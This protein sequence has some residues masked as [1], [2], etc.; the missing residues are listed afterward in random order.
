MALEKTGE[1]L[2]NLRYTQQ[3]DTVQNANV[4]VWVVSNLDTFEG[5]KLVVSAL[6]NAIADP[7]VRVSIIHN[8]NLM[9]EPS[10]RITHPESGTKFS[11]IIYQALY[12]SKISLDDL[13]NTFTSALQPEDHIKLIDQIK[14]YAAGSPI[15]EMITGGHIKDWNNLYNKLQDS[16]LDKHFNGVVVNGRIVGPIPSNYSFDKEDF[17][18]LISHEW[19]KR[20]HPVITAFHELQ[21]QREEGFNVSFTPEMVMQLSSVIT[22]ADLT[23]DFTIFVQQ[24]GG[25]NRVYRK[26]SSDYSRITSGDIDNATYQFGIILDPVSENAQKWSAI[27][28]TLAHL[29]GVHIEIY[30]NPI[31]QL[32]ALPLKRF[33]RYVMDKELHFNEHGEIEHPTAYFANLPEDPLYTLGTEEI[34]SWHISP[35]VANYDLDNILLKSID[36]SQRANGVSAVFELEYILIDGHCRDMSSQGPPRGL[37]FVLGSTNSPSM[38]DTIVMANLGY[39][40]LKANPGVWQLSL[41]EGRSQEIY[42]LESVGTEGWLSPTVEESGNSIALLTFEGA[43]IYPRV[44]KYKGKEQEDVLNTA[45]TSNTTGKDEDEGTWSYLK[46]K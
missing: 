21:E 18:L 20:I 17:E 19:K 39:F 41:R 9:A 37:Q 2:E 13:R 22:R 29:E 38:T 33:Y 42:Q 46:N 12:E 27:L 5:I 26:L 10:S 28:E 34:K 44:K 6:E 4:S 15:V 30:L 43:T 32:S 16:G 45:V 8:P 25:R 14:A 23:E 24:R 1:I 7:N 11:N 35:K 31:P 36:K 3:D 40:Q